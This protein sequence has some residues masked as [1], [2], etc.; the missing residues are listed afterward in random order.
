MIACGI[1]KLSPAQMSKLHKGLPVRVKAGTA[2]QVN[3]PPT[4]AKN[5]L[6]QRLIIKE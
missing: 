6:K 2:H 4:Q 1:Q 3:L 5:L